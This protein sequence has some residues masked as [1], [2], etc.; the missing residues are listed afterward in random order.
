MAAGLRSL[1]EKYHI[2]PTAFIRQA[3][4][5]KIQRDIPQL[6]CKKKQDEIILPF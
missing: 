3:I 4:A 5:E 2:K 6:R 1:K